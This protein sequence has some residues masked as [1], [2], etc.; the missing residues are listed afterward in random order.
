MSG[1]V[2]IDDDLKI[3]YFQLPKIHDIMVLGEVVN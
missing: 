2:N 3:H 1:I